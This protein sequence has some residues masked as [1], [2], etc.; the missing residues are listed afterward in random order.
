VTVDYALHSSQADADTGEL[1]LAVQALEGFEESLRVSHIKT[2]AVIGYA[3]A[4]CPV[5]ILRIDSDQW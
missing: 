4:A 2:G 3:I 5:A 1:V